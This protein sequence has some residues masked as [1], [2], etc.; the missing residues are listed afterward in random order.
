M[1][2]LPCMDE[3]RGVRQFIIQE[4]IGEPGRSEISRNEIIPGDTI[5]IPSFP[6]GEISWLIEQ[7]G[8]EVRRYPL[9][10]AEQFQHAINQRPQKSE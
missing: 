1:L 6:Q 10:R 9:N 7:D 2:K 5:H 8:V 3:R 4:V